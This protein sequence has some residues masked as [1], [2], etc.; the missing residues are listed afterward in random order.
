MSD[1]QLIEP[2]L[3]HIAQVLGSCLQAGD[4]VLLDGAM[5]AGKTTFTR[6]LAQGLNLDHPQNVCS[7][8]FSLAVDHP[9]P[10]P[11][12]HVDLFRLQE[13]DPTTHPSSAAFEALG[14]DFDQLALADAVT[15]VEWAKYWQKRPNDYVAISLHRPVGAVGLRTLKVHAVGQRSQT[16]L[17]TWREKLGQGQHFFAQS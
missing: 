13:E 3:Q 4:V 1:I 2:Q 14:I 7:P 17:Q 6:A 12:R 11:L 5:G 10:I 8:S 16:L 15:V 9:G